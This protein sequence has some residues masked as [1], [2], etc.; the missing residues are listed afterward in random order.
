MTVDMKKSANRKRPTDLKRAFLQNTEGTIASMAALI[1]PVVI[2]VSGAAID[3]QRAEMVRLR[4]QDH[5]DH[6]VL[7]GA[8]MNDVGAAENWFDRSTGPITGVEINR[9]FTNGADGT[10]DGTVNANVRPSFL[11]IFGLDSIPVEINS[12]AKS[13]TQNNPCVTLLDTSSSQSLLVN[14]GAHVAMPR[15]EI[16]VHSTASPAA[17]FNSGSDLD[18]AK[19]CIKRDRI[20]NN[21]SSIDNIETSCAVRDDPYAS[22][23]PQPAVGSCTR[24][25]ENFNGGTVNLSPGVYCGQF[26]FNGRS[27]VNLAPGLYVIKEGGWNVGEGIWR[28]EGVSFYF[29]D[30][31]R[32]QFNSGIE[33]HLSA[34]TTGPYRDYL[35]FEKTG[36]SKSN[37]I[38]NDDNGTELVGIIYLPSRDVI[39]NSGSSIEGDKLSMVFNN[40]I[41]NNTDW[42][43]SPLEGVGRQ[44]A[45][46]LTR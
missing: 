33:A 40:L 14:S 18:A 35:F 4:L 46:R 31:S 3:L 42:K 24:R 44:V 6:A 17:V 36:L 9:T 21:R 45:P 41:I 13:E 37:F 26:N 27:N 29:A 32:I 22:S 5:L 11:A 1:I 39:Y 2:L 20:I 8:K 43:I 15:C 30:T 25:N 16:H 38:F 12:S 34:P 19:I 23:V 28:G 7:N 10:I